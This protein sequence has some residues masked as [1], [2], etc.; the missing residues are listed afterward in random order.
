MMLS[1]TQ[2]KLGCYILESLFRP[3]LGVVKV[4]SRGGSPLP[5]QLEGDFDSGRIMGSDRV[6]TFLV[7]LQRRPLVLF[8]Q[9]I[10]MMRTF[11][12]RKQSFEMAKKCGEAQ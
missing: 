6:L 4:R 10:L 5:Y 2:A 3:F 7:P 8:L 11:P 9:V 12:A 1:D